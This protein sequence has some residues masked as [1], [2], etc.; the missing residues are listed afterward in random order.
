MRFAKQRSLPVRSFQSPNRARAA[1]AP[2][3]ILKPMAG[4][5]FDHPK[6]ELIGA[7]VMMAAFLTLALFA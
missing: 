3:T 4:I 7:C 1:V 5:R 2:L 6:V